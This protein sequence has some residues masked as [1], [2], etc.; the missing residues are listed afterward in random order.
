MD[1]VFYNFDFVFNS[2]Y[3]FVKCDLT[4]HPKTLVIYGFLYKGKIV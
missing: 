4:V 1:L 2:E 3:T